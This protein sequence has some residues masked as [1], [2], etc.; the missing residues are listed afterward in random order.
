MTGQDAAVR[1]MAR[2][3]APPAR[4]AAGT[5]LH[6]VPC[7]LRLP[8]AQTW[9]AR[10]Q[11]LSPL[12]GPLQYEL[13]LGTVSFLSCA[14]ISAQLLLSL[15]VVNCPLPPGH[16]TNKICSFFLVHVFWASSVTAAFPEPYSLATATIFPN[17]Y[18]QSPIFSIISE[19]KQFM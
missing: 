7:G 14:G 15:R 3:I 1:H 4:K 18:L 5:L 17:Y 16:L 2:P 11:S 6:A 9:H 8:A 13:C 12:S 19:L 10:E